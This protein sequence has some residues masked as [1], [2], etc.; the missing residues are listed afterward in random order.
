MLIGVT[1]LAGAGKSEVARR[2]TGKFG[3][4]RYAF[5]DPL[6]GMLASVGFTDAQLYGREKEANLPEFGRTP[7]YAMQTLGTEWGRRTM[8]PDFWVRIWGR[9]MVAK[10]QS[11]GRL[12]ADDVRF[13]NEVR[14]IRD[15][16]GYIVHVRRPGVSARPRWGLFGQA[17]A[18]MGLD[19]AFHASER[20]HRLGY[21][22]LI[23][24]DGDLIDLSAK[25]DA[26]MQSM[27]AADA[28]SRA[29]AIHA[30]KAA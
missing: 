12:V 30:A 11:A 24:N 28:R 22:F 19:W 21:D 2:L 29:R 6:K 17:L 8:H 4:A 18:R 10:W 15:R 25:I 26:A 5:A 23:E 9:Q 16:G 1:G 20:P 13:P 3:C 27:L 14:A 7:R